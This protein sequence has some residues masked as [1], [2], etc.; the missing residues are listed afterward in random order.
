[1]ADEPFTPGR[2][3]ALARLFP[4]IR[5]LRG[6]GLSLQ[7]KKLYL[8]ALGLVLLDSGW[9]AL[10]RLFPGS[11]AHFAL[12]RPNWD[13]A[14]P[15]RS[16]SIPAYLES[17]LVR[18]TEPVQVVLGP[19]VQIFSLRI[20]GR[21]WVHACLAAVWALAVWGIIGGAI[22]RMATVQ[23]SAGMRVGMRRALWFALG[24]AT[25]LVGGPLTPLLGV[26]L[27]TGFCALFGLLYRVPAGP[28]VA[29]VLFVLPLVAGLV[30]AT[31]L[32]G[33]AAGWPLVHASVAA[34]ADD[35]FDALSRSYA[36]VFQ[37]PGRYAAYLLLAWAVGLT[38]VVFVDVFSRGIVH[39]A[40]W[41]LSLSVPGDALPRLL[42]A[43]DAGSG[44]TPAIFHGFWL[45]VVALLVRAWPFAYF[46]T[47]ASL[48]YLL[49]RQEIDGTDFHKIALPASLASPLSPGT[50][51]LGAKHDA[52]VPAAE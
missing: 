42:H 13:F 12:A 52:A 1:M 28:A 40:Q 2:E 33:L 3:V 45:A 22:A 43:P 19:F 10:D 9:R 32:L 24:K 5:L 39:L 11:Q 4:S 30:M 48:I 46:W 7:F 31:I 38:G 36:Y 20:D 8:A 14:T 35:G 34:E 41:G 25:P 37:R 21:S 44:S 17:A 47:T 15:A 50:A 18:L 51:P 6:V 23:V 26:A 49:L 27:C 29:G 16:L